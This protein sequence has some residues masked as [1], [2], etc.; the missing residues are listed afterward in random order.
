MK[1]AVPSAQPKL[2]AHTEAELHCNKYMLIIDI[3]TM[4]YEAIAN[5]VTSQEKTA[6]VDLLV[7]KLVQK[8][9]RKVLTDKCSCDMQKRFWVAGIQTIDV[10]TGT[11]RSMV[12]QLKEVCMAETL[13]L[14]VREIL[15]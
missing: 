9:V 6:A 11:A 13:I 8:S 12:E 10:D 7:Q 4:R 1:V 15:G 2:D 14:P 5:P 3:D